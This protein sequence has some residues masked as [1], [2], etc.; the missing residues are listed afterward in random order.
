MKFPRNILAITCCLATLW[1]CAR[2]PEPEVSGDL[3]DELAEIIPDQ[4]TDPAIVTAAPTM[5]F[6]M[7]ANEWVGAARVDLASGDLIPPHTAGVRYVYPLT[8]GTLSVVDNNTE[9]IVH[10]VPGELATWP[11][12]RLSLSNVDESDC[13]F[14]LIERSPVE[15][16]PE[17]E[18][19]AFPD[20]AVDMERHGTVLLDD[21]SVMV[22]DITLE[23]RAADPLPV[24][25]PMLVAAL[26]PCDLKFQ[27]PEISEDERVLAEGEAAW[28]TAG[29]NVVSNA[30][31][32][33]AHFVVF[34]FRK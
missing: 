24:N 31:D 26:S 15:T 4:P 12:G 19:L 32:A 28:Q 18:T 25:L 14:L 23:Q 1:G 11:A 20:V 8:Q 3:T 21:D 2:Q 6:T 7:F 9:E 10:L 34:G 5:A 22:V 33:T 29:Y 27:G 17:L 13:H 30:G 16:S